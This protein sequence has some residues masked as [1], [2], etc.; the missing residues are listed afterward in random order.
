M[1]QV[2]PP[3]TAVKVHC[4]PC[5]I[6]EGGPRLTS[7]LRLGS[8]GCC[9]WWDTGRQPGGQIALLMWRLR[10]SLPR[11]SSQVTDGLA[12]VSPPSHCRP[13]TV[14]RCTT[15]GGGFICRGVSSDS[16]PCRLLWQLYHLLVGRGQ[17]RRVWLSDRC[18]LGHAQHR[19]GQCWHL[20]GQSA[21]AGPS[22]DP[23]HCAP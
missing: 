16:P 23:L 5:G 1:L 14:L 13:P 10:T 3:A 4:Q 2:L 15:H 18:R 19:R 22:R 17:T 12:A 20:L 6:V 21:W 7:P 8:L 9:W 11:Y